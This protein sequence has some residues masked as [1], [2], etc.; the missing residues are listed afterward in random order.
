MNTGQIAGGKF[1]IDH[2]SHD[3]DNDALTCQTL[4]L[5]PF[6]AFFRI[7]STLIRFEI[8]YPIGREIKNSQF[9][10]APLALHKTIP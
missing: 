7:K 9:S 4:I 5:L 8:Q 1:N 6:T 2:D 10:Q 3:S